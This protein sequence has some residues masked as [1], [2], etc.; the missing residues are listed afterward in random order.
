MSIEG[1]AVAGDPLYK[2]A[3]PGRANE[4]DGDTDSGTAAP[5][6]SHDHESLIYVV[7]GL[8]KTVVGDESFVL[9][10]GDA[11]RHPRNVSHYID[12]L[13]DSTFVEIKSPAPDLARLYGM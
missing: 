1:K 6:H 2:T 5:P 11:C 12:A 7:D 8:L 13:A 10:P 3:D 4:P 9:G